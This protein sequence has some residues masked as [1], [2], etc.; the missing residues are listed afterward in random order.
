MNIIK[1]SKYLSMILR[2]RPQAAGIELDAH[3]WADIDELLAGMQK[4]Y[5]L[6]DRE[7][8]EQIVAR[9]EKQRYAFD[10]THARLRANQG[11]SIQVDVELQEKKTPDVLWHGSAGR[12]DHAIRREGLKPMSRLY[13]HLS[14]DIETALKVGKRHGEPVV[15]AVD[16]KAMVKDGYHFYLSANNVWLTRSVPPH[17]LREEGSLDNK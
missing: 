16:T 1:I 2:H 12:F 3:G 9:D 4:R 15:Y 13:V 14:K 7:M 5:P 11:H 17:Y 6:F 10:E 8:L